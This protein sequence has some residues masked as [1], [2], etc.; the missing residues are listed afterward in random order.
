MIT[1][2]HTA[3]VNSLAY[4]FAWLGLMEHRAECSCSYRGRWHIDKQQA[5]RDATEHAA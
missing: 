1:T 2:T 4:P 3:T 5:E